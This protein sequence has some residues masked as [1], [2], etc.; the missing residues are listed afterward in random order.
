MQPVPHKLYAEQT[1]EQ[2]RLMLKIGDDQPIVLLVYDRMLPRATSLLTLTQLHLL[3]GV[4]LEKVP[5]VATE[6]QVN[7]GYMVANGARPAVEASM[8]GADPSV[9]DAA[10]GHLA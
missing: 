2:S 8:A 6:F 4:P 3:G 7:M 1:D 5:F 9:P 10:S